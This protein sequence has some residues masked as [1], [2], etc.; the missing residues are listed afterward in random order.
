M[1]G[2]AGPDQYTL[3][4]RPWR[5][6]TTPFSRIVSQE[7]PGQGSESDPYLIDWLESDP[8]NPMTW[9]TTYKLVKGDP[10]L[11]NSQTDLRLSCFDQFRWLVT[12]TVAI[13]TLAVAMA[14][15][16]L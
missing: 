6:Y 3:K 1:V 7:Y 2:D 8:E 12:L 16:T 5:R 4:F 10:R 9:K 11:G 13:A 15:S 14:S